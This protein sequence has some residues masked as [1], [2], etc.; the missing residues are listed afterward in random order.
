METLEFLRAPFALHDDIGFFTVVLLYS[1]PLVVYV[2]LPLYWIFYRKP[3]KIG[4]AFALL[5]L[6]LLLTAAYS[7]SGMPDTSQ[8]F[9]VMALASLVV[10]VCITVARFEYYLLKKLLATLNRKQKG[11]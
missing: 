6:N 3:A 7:L 2:F 10:P 1:M 8:K 4:G 9:S 5:F 11:I